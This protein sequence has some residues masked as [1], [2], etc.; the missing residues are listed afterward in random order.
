MY[1]LADGIVNLYTMSGYQKGIVH[2]M[3]YMKLTSLV[4]DVND[5]LLFGVNLRQE[6]YSKNFNAGSKA[7]HILT[8]DKT[9]LGIK[10]YGDYLFW[11]DESGALYVCHKMSCLSKVALGKRHLKN[12]IN[13][14]TIFDISQ[15]PRGNVKLQ[16]FNFIFSRYKLIYQF[17]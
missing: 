17:Y 14:I 5:K 10:I 6:I 13:G 8:H 2:F 4:V 15:Q 1:I 9:L 7:T 16:F 11:I 3:Y 12:P